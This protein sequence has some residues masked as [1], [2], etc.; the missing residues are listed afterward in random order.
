[1]QFHNGGTFLPLPAIWLKII[2]LRV[3]RDLVALQLRGG[4]PER[5]VKIVLVR[6]PLKQI[7][8]NKQVLGK[9]RG[10]GRAGR[11]AIRLPL[12]LLLAGGVFLGRLP[13]LPLLRLLVNGRYASARRRGHRNITPC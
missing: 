8:T 3:A 11:N 13:L 4:I 6:H 9:L 10:G 5:L 2:V 7:K 1:M 12:L